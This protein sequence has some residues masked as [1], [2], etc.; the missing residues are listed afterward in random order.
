M[1]DA[2]EMLQRGMAPAEGIGIGELMRVTGMSRP[3]LYRYLAQLALAGREE[4]VR[5]GR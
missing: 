1:A 4:Q 2:T 5:W 3:T